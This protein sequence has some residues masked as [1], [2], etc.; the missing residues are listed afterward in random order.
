MKHILYLAAIV[1]AC[2]CPVIAGD[3]TPKE[4]ISGTTLVIIGPDEPV[5][6]GQEI[7]LTMEGLTLQELME[8]Q[9]DG[10]FELT[11]FPLK[12]VKVDANYDWLE[13]RL[14]LDFKSTMPG[15]FL[16]KMQIDRKV[17][18]QTNEALKDDKGELI[19][20]VTVLPVRDIA[21]IVVVVE[22]DDDPF[23]D[24]DPDP[25]PDPSPLPPLP[26]LQV[27][28]LV[29]QDDRGSG[30]EGA[31]LANH[32][33][34]V[35]EYLKPLPCQYRIWDPDQEAG[36]EFLELLKLKSPPISPPAVILTVPSTETGEMMLVDAVTFG[37]TG[38][39][40]VAA[41]KELGVKQ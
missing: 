22:G 40:T 34:T 3:I 1:A 12:G 41:L 8:A 19:K 10:R 25:D 31:A 21:A 18:W 30:T 23:P 13:R 7:E 37:S 24:P 5:Q 33:E 4:A 17:E 9:D 11:I 2:C 16:I 32:V 15:E 35:R 36:K 38:E 6:V 20:Y 29:E 14:E 28:L 27:T 26:T 39:A